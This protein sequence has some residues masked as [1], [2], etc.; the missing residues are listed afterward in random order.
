M[1]RLPQDSTFGP[2]L[3]LYTLSLSNLIHLHNFKLHAQMS[4]LSV[5]PTCLT[6][7]HFLRFLKTSHIHHN[8]WT[9]L[10]PLKLAPQSIFSTS[11]NGNATQSDSQT[12]N[13]GT[14]FGFSL[15]FTIH[16][17]LPVQSILHTSQMCF[18]LLHSHN[19]NSLLTDLPAA[20]LS[21]CN[22]SNTLLLELAS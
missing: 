13:L 22:P 20:N 11:I 19:H 10:L 12:R 2:V 15:S 21:H 7:N 6:E 4:L 17:I 5:R 8:H 14:I 9:S 18:L 3:R 16:H 1:L